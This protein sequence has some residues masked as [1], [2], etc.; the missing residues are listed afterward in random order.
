MVA[1]ADTVP[2]EKKEVI[3]NLYHSGIPEEFIT[4]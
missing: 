3:K 1:A 4:M 2:S